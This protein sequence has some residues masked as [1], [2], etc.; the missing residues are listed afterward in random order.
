[1]GSEMSGQAAAPGT[2]EQVTRE[3]AL[4]LMQ[5]GRRPTVAAV[6]RITRRGSSSTIN[7]ILRD[8]MIELAAAASGGEVRWPPGLPPPVVGAATALWE[9]ALAAARASY[10]EQLGSTDDG[11]GQALERARA[12]DE[13]RV[14]AEGE[15]DML[16]RD[17][18]RLEQMH[19][20]LHRQLEEAVRARRRAEDRLA[21]LVSRSTKRA[22]GPQAAGRVKKRRAGKPRVSRTKVRR[23]RHKR[24]PSPR[25][26]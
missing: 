15:R 19:G 16:R 25:S 26:A 2:T 10:Q 6:R 21:R 3:A 4:S 5:Q 23:P 9:A 12:A 11:L 22:K 17:N 13:A 20:E 14:R 1:M 7:R 24:P 8:L 18:A